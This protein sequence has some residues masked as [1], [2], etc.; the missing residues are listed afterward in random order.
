MFFNQM[1]N[2]AEIKY[3]PTKFEMAGLIWVVRKIRHMIK[4]TKTEM[5]TVIFT[6]YTVNISI[7]K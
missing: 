7:A 2:D 6:D 5:T 1:F 4:A 3:W